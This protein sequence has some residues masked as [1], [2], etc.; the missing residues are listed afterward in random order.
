MNDDHIIYLCPG[1]S[2]FPLVSVASSKFFRITTFEIRD[3]H[4]DI[5]WESSTVHFTIMAFHATVKSDWITRTGYFA[6]MVISDVMNNC[7]LFEG[8]RYIYSR[9]LIR[10][11]HD[12]GS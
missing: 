12:C 2:Q 3:F 7:S 10:L 4:L 6:N 1:Y 5:E 8:S 9:E 11:S